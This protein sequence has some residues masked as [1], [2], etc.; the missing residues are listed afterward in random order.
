ME[1][2]NQEIRQTE[3]LRDIISKIPNNFSKIILI[4]ILS[5]L[6]IMIVLGIVIKVPGQIDIPAKITS[7]DPPVIL[8]SHMTGK[9]ALAIDSFPS[10]CVKNSIIGTITNP[11]STNDVY[12]LKSLLEKTDI[13]ASE[14]IID[15]LFD[16]DLTL[17]RLE[18]PYTVFREKLQAYYALKANS[19]YYYQI[20]YTNQI[21]KNKENVL[22]QRN[23]IKNNTELENGILNKKLKTDSL[24]YKKKVILT[25]ELNNSFLEKIGSQN[26]IANLKIEIANLSQEIQKLKMD[27]NKL[28]IDFHREL[29]N[30][31]F[32]VVE[33]H[34][35]LLS[36]IQV[37]E[38]NYVFIT[39]RNAH[40]ELANIIS[41]GD[42]VTEG[43][44]LFH[45]V[46][47]GSNYYCIATLPPY[48][49]GEVKLNQAV[50][51]KLDLYPYQEYGFLEGK[52]LSIT[53]NTID[54][55]Y[56]VQI[57]LPNGLH[58][59]NGFELLFAESMT[60]SAEIIT[61]NKR[62]I[63]VILYKLMNAVKPNKMKADEKKSKQVSVGK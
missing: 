39:H 56:L 18:D 62:L 44:P 38:D 13:Y 16:K 37:W 31:R 6:I 8:R 19:T 3:E 23:I 34:Q 27:L 28:Q 49:A 10:Y 7:N 2:N 50:N 24:L 45:L 9:I 17:G 30:A 53:R 48:G 4:G 52:V 41:T 55:Y 58:S 46:F 59:S 60:G 61:E 12:F 11:A 25:D 5:L 1:Q 40:V 35:N 21:I 36:N 32:A 47:N 26:Q 22:K 20:E 14:V 33:S 15:S 29:R 42:F 43:Q 57:T 54:D 63:E 51:I